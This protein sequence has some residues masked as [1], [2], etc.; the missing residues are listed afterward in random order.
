MDLLNDCAK[1]YP[2]KRGRVSH[3]I[4]QNPILLRVWLVMTQLVS[5]TSVCDPLP[6]ASEA[7][8]ISHWSLSKP[9]HLWSL[10]QKTCPISQPLKRGHDTLPDATE[11]RPESESDKNVAPNLSH[12]LHTVAH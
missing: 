7:P 2:I 6:D 10:M 4:S 1:R 11:T 5:E 8:V 12:Y 9:F 3:I